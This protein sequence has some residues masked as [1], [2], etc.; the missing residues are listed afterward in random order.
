VL[1]AIS[2]GVLA[3][4]APELEHLEPAARV[5]WKDEIGELD[6]LV[7]DL[8]LVHTQINLD[9]HERFKA[10][11]GAFHSAAQEQVALS[12]DLPR[13]LLMSLDCP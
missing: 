1:I 13:S 3:K 4:L 8:N 7:G 11:M 9:K 10:S 5:I 12:M 2:Q 6:N